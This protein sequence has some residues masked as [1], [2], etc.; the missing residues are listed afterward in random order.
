M[1]LENKVAIVTGSAMGIGK[2]IV[3]DFVNEGAKV[4][5]SDILEAEGQALEEELQKKGHSVYFFKTDVSSEKNIKEL[6]KFTLEKFGTINILCNNAAVNIPGSV[7]ELTE[8]IWNKTMDVN[9][10]SHF[11]VSKHVIPVMQKAGG[12]SIVNTASANSFVAEPRLSAY[13]ASKGAILMLTRAMALDFAKDNIRVNCICP[14]WVDTTF[15]DAH[16]ELFGGREA[17]LKDLASVQPIGR[18]IAPM[19]IAKIATFLASD[20]SSCMTGSPVIADGGIT[21]GV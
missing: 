13:V 17:V 12:G 16:A 9:V 20:D 19:E 4:I 7:L 6:V 2:A 14:G 18:P 5:I 8:D 21:A 15:N 3:R 1:R 10:K 11:L